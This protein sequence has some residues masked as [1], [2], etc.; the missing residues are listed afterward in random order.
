MLDK[1]KSL[2]A[3]LEAKAQAIKASIVSELPTAKLVVV[4]ATV[5]SLLTILAQLLHKI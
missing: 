3:S 2:I 1:L 4:S 5:G